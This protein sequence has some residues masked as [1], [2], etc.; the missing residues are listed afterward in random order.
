MRAF[1]SE[2]LQSFAF[3][4]INTRV[5]GPPILFSLA[6]ALKQLKIYLQLPF[7]RNFV[8]KER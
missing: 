3:S 4:I 8:D 2:I 1:F 5:S 6:L 7:E